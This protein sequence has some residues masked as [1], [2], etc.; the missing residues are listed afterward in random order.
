MFVYIEMVDSIQYQRE[1]R[2]SMAW[3][4]QYDLVDTV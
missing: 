3:S 4:T 1:C 2:H